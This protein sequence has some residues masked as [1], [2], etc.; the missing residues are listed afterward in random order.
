[1]ENYLESDEGLPGN[2]G[3]TTDLDLP[4]RLYFGVLCIIVGLIFSL[5]VR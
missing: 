1:M 5:L 2:E 4:I 3:M